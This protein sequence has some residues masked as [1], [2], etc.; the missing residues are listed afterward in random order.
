MKLKRKNSVLK[1]TIEKY[2][3]GCDKNNC[4]HKCGCYD[5]SQ[6]FINASLFD[7]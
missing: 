4:N 5:T 7:W 2:T 3:C 6:G 1:N